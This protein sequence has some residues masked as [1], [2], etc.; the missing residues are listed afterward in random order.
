MSNRHVP[1]YLI[2]TDVETSGTNVPGRIGPDQTPSQC[3]SIGIIIIDTQH[4]DQIG[5]A[6]V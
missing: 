4:P 5:R 6:H 2:G 3:L 1:R